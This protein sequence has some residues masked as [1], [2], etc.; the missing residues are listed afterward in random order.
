[1][2]DLDVKMRLDLDYQGRDA[3]R[4]KDDIEALR[5]AAQRLSGLGADKLEGDLKQ[6]SAGA[7]KASAALGKSTD[8]IKLLNRQ[9]TDKAEGEL[10]ALQG[11]ANSLAAKLDKPVTAFRKLNA[12]NTNKAEREMQELGAAASKA[13]ERLKKIDKTKFTGVGRQ[14]DA[15]RKKVD[16]L[17][18]RVERLNRLNTPVSKLDSTVGALGTT[19]VGA[20]GS[21]VAFAS[22]DNILRGLNQLED[23]FN[24]VD[25]AATRV[26]LTAEQYDPAVVQEMKSVNARI[27]EKTGLKVG[28]VSDARN[29]FAAAN[30]PIAQQNKILE[31]VARAAV[32]SGSS[33]EVIAK[34][35]TAGLNNLGLTQEDIPTYLDQMLK[36]GKVGEFEIEAMAASFPKLAALYANT[37]GTGL[38]AS[39][40]MIAAAQ[41]IR[42]GAGD[43]ASAATNFENFMSKIFAKD[44]VKNFDEMG[45]DVEKLVANAQKSGQSPIWAVLDKIIEKTGGDEFKLNELFGDMQVKA[46][47]RPLIANRDLF[48]EY[49]DEV[50]NKSGGLVE[51]DF[52]RISQ[53][54]EAKSNRRGAT[55]ANILGGVGNAWGHIKNPVLDEVTGLINPDYRRREEGIV[56]KER[57]KDVNIE[58]LEAEI[59]DLKAQIASRPKPKL[60]LPDNGLFPLQ[61]RLRSAE[62]ELEDALKVQGAKATPLDGK[63]QLPIPKVKPLGSDKLSALSDGM[64]PAGTEAGQ[65]FSANMSDEVGQMFSLADDLKNAYSFT[66]TPTISPSF[67]AASGPAPQVQKMSSVTSGPVNQTI[68]GVSNPYRAASLLNRRQN[69]EIR[70]SRSRALHETGNL[71]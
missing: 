54:P 67:S 34:S 10:K 57:L 16:R 37:G 42:K 9:T 69:R 24:K 4:A 29:V 6:V 1:M 7:D 27:S 39:A 49:R 31:P 19:A 46:A 61:Q 62:F 44:A 71:A 70:G 53:T 58:A 25:L 22:V 3:K 2:S 51:K 40:D 18:E 21:L 14:A 32:A 5:K 35:V 30:I 15:A 45:V 11:A 64:G 8:K 59:A 52:D 26:A 23:G 13:A 48:D 38:T 20:F 68:N 17:G 41:I 28:G 56:E 43:E 63:T 36:G 66:A 12:L 55:W 60:D 47:L 65:K 33:P 50:L